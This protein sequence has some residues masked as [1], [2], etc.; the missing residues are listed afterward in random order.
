M[1]LKNILF[2]TFFIFT[3]SSLSTLATTDRMKDPLTQDLRPKKATNLQQRNNKKYGVIGLIT[4]TVILG[5]VYR[6]FNKKRN[7]TPDNACAHKRV[8]DKMLKKQREPKNKVDREERLK[9]EEEERQK[10]EA[11][12]RKKEEERLKNENEERLKKEEEERLK[13][14]KVLSFFFDKE[15]RCIINQITDENKYLENINYLLE[16]YIMPLPLLY[17]IIYTLPCRMNKYSISY[18]KKLPALKKY[19]EKIETD[20]EIRNKVSKDIPSVYVANTYISKIKCECFLGDIDFNKKQ[21]EENLNIVKNEL[22]KKYSVIK[23]LYDSDK[24]EKEVEFFNTKSPGKKNALLI[25]AKEDHN[26]SLHTWDSMLLFQIQIKYALNVIQVSSLD[27]IRQK[28]DKVKTQYDLIILAGHGSDK[29]ITLSKNESINYSNVHLLNSMFNKI[30]TSNTQFILQ[31]CATGAKKAAE[32]SFNIAKFFSFFATKKGSKVQSYT[33]SSFIQNIFFNEDKLS[34]FINP[35][36]K[37]G[38]KIKDYGNVI[39][40]K[41]NECTL[42]VSR[43]DGT[44][45][46]FIVNNVIKSVLRFESRDKVKVSLNNFPYSISQNNKLY[47]GS[48]EGSFIGATHLGVYVKFDETTDFYQKTNY[49]KTKFKWEYI[50]A[51]S[52]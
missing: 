2:Y 35:Y 4:T 19:L 31:S 27:E 17:S 41:K 47:T 3:S 49:S 12:E 21:I 37:D 33:K 9:K 39:L 6:L 40:K 44:K 50:S 13:K 51:L 5:I 8:L 14:E 24:G 48:F 20:K 46:E 28:L 36:K 22:K 29:T 16:N 11:E 42:Q 7:F 38:E 45:Y 1:Q 23:L 52:Q 10:R 18:D 15:G 32:N 26:S 25:L 43:P 30:S 34:I